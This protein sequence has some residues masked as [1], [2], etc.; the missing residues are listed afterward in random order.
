MAD[1]S[2]DTPRGTWSPGDDLIALLPASLSPEERRYLLFAAVMAAEQEALDPAL[3]CAVIEQESSWQTRA[4]REE[5]AIKDASYGLMQVLGG[6][7]RG[8]GH[9]GPPEDL[10]E[11]TVGCR[12]GCDFLRQMLDL[13]GQ[14]VL[15][16]VAAY[17]AGPTAV[18]AN[19]VY[20]QERG[21]LPTE[22]FQVAYEHVLKVFRKVERYRPVARLSAAESLSDD[23]RQ[24]LGLLSA[25]GAGRESVERW[26]N[27]IGRAKEIG[28]TVRAL[29]RPL[30]P[31]R[32]SV[33]LRQGNA[34]SLDGLGTELERF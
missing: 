26:V 27:Q 31:K 25:L 32:V 30:T 33:A 21:E 14:D 8:M 4:Y 1:E 19:V 3:V 5:P 24:T 7:A 10:Y 2:S 29:A 11:P 23:Q 28:A 9:T 16:A 22:A 34:A 15:L 17:N 12:Y 20:H 6:T 13:F 18:R